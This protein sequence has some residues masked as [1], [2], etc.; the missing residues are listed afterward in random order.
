[1]TVKC[2][3]ELIK[4]LKDDDHLVLS[5]DRDFAIVRNKYMIGF[6]DL[7]VQRIDFSI[8]EEMHNMMRLIYI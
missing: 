4:E 6:I 3:K 8:G 5:V 2:F 1:M 7:H